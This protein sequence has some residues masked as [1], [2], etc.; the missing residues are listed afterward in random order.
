M[1]VKM[2]VSQTIF[3]LIKRGVCVSTPG[4]YLSASLLERNVSEIIVPGFVAT[5]EHTNKHIACK[6]CT[7]VALRLI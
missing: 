7:R 5:P 6:Y 3:K 4:V 1:N 2:V